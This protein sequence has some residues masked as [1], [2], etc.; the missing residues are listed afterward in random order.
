MKLTPHQRT[1]EK[2]RRLETL[3][4]LIYEEKNR[5]TYLDLTAEQSRLEQEILNSVKKT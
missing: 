3:A 5:K 1:Y 4:V 2:L